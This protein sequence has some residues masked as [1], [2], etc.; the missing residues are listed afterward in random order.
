MN[1]VRGKIHRDMH[2]QNTTRMR[3]PSAILDEFLLSVLGDPV[4]QY[5]L[6]Y[7]VLVLDGSG[8]LRLCCYGPNVDYD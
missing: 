3:R 8:Q 4:V 2:I 6:D 1:Y 5:F 7:R